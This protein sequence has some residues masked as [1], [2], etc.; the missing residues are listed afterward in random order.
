MEGAINKST[1]WTEKYR[2]D[3]FD[4]VVG[5]EEIIREL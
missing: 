3:N 5:Q 1:I 4:G 2:P